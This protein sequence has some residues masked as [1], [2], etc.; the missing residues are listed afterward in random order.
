MEQYLEAGKVATAHGVRGDL[1]VESWCD[2]PKVLAEL[3]C[4]YIGKEKTA[5]KVQKGSVHRG[6][7]L[8]HLEGIEDRDAALA[9]KDKTVYADR[10]ELP[11]AE[12]AYFVV[13]MMGAD[14]VDADSGHVYGRITDLIEG[15]ASL[16]YEVTGE[17]GSALLPAIP[18]FVVRTE[19]GK[20]LYVRVIEG[21]L[22]EI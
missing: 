3:K 7:A 12:G 19:P 2:S 18:Q 16:L 20:A 10:S 1:R 21:L 22:D 14:V 9:L 17:R 11:L 13:D 5:Y 8:L 15:A 6:M 4:I